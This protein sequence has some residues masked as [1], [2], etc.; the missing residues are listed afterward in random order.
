MNGV[1][2]E[3]EDRGLRLSLSYSLRWPHFSASVG[4]VFQTVIWGPFSIRII[5]G[6]GSKSVDS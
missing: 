5:M 3:K 1:D 4:I 2:N 6:I